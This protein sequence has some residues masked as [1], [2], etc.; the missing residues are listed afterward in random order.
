MKG[1]A[2][3]LDSDI[4]D[5]VNFVD[6]N[7]ILSLASDVST[8][9]AAK[10]QAKRGRKRQRVTMPPKQKSKV[11]KTA[12]VPAKK[13]SN[14][15]TAAAKRK[16]LEDHVHRL[17][18]DEEGVGGSDAEHQAPVPVARKRARATTKGKSTARS[19]INNQTE[20]D[21]MDVE[22]A[23]VVACSNQAASQNDREMQKSVSRA[24][25]PSKSKAT[26]QN[27]PVVPEIQQ[28]EIEEEVERVAP[29]IT[30][31][32]PKTVVRDSSIRQELH[33]RRRAGSTSDTER[34]DPN[35]RR[36]LG[37]I[38]R[39]FENVDLKYRNLKEVGINE[40]NAN[41]EKLRKQCDA[42]MQASNE[43]IA[44][45]KK[46]L[47]AQAPL[48][49]EARKLKKQIE[50][51]EAEDARM[52]E[53]VSELSNSLSN[54]QNEIRAL[55]AKLAAARASSIENTNSRTPGSAIKS[56]L[57]RPMMIGNAEAAQAA[58][59][60]QMKED[61]YSDLTGLIIRSVKKTDEVETYDCIQTG[62]NGSKS[63]RVSLKMQR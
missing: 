17:D 3:L 52:R 12:T 5:Q 27:H 21:L 40:A 56:S 31:P 36:K 23:P 41:M 55:Q 9:T 28:E 33:F 14:K 7:S 24:T 44:S 46:E 48:V 10:P 35:L 37:D 26:Q 51:K 39:K 38:T 22:Q 1:I 43:L 47:A 57:Q 29:I 62:R 34:G 6:E 2:D 50:H 53:T 54:A 59:M 25:V 60:A 4:E 18:A 45:L 20:D 16:A 63:N 58:Q 15:Q 32:K 19:G 42:T 8:A 13:A 11:Q 61:L 49:Q 30:A